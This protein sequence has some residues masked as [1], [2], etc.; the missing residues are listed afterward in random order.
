VYGLQQNFSGLN[1]NVDG[2]MY[3]IFMNNV[4]GAG[5]RKN[6][7]IYTSKGL[8]RLGDS[9]LITD[10]GSITPR[11]VLDVNASSA[12]IV[13]TGTSAQ[14][15]AAA[16]SV[17]GMVRYNTDN[18]GRLESYNGSAWSGILSGGIGIDPPNI[19]ANGGITVSFAFT[20]ATVGA[21][22]TI[23]PSTAP[24]NGIV[25]AWARVSAANTIEVRFQNCTGAGINPPSL[26]YNI[27]VIQ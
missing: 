23:S 6:Y 4:N 17:A 18:G 21:T 20:G 7:A 5:P 12:M 10:G 26:G 14:R 2:T 1:N 8:N 3:G 11:A 9:V 24:P 13:P 19:V 16:A 25:I 15:P 22:V 27:R